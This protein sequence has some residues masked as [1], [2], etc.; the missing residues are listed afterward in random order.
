MSVTDPVADMLTRVKNASV[1]RHSK[2]DMPVSR[3]KI[4][5]AKILKGEGY[6]KNYKVLKDKTHPTLR[7]YLKYDGNNRAAIVGLKRISKPGRRV[8]VPKKS[9][10]SVMSGL[11]IAVLSTSKGIMTDREARKQSV[12][13][14]VLCNVW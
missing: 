14:E 7:V 2:V 3:M 10:P 5:V 4:S 13:G 8:Y 12:G 6:I 11:G 1:A 9:L